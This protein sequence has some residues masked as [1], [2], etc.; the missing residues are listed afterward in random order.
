MVR[1]L[2]GDTDTNDQL[3]QDE[4]INAIL[5]VTTNVKRAASRVLRSIA[6][7]WAR[8]VDIA[9]EGLSERGS[10][11]VTAWRNLAD[12]LETEADSESPNVSIA[13]VRVA[14]YHSSNL[15]TESDLE[16]DNALR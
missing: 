8:D 13:G 9:G 16:T 2:I 12:E 4:E 7:R 15:F 14:G 1:F 6:A 5:A 3:V 10:Q 11:R